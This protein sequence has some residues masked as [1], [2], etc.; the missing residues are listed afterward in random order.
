MNTSAAE[1]ADK[2]WFREDIAWPANDRPEEL[3]T[4]RLFNLIYQPFFQDK[5]QFWQEY[6][7]YKDQGLILLYV[8]FDAKTPECSYTE[9]AKFLPQIEEGLLIWE[10][11][12]TIRFAEE[13][14]AFLGIGHPD[15]RKFS[16]KNKPMPN[17]PA[18]EVCSALA[19]LKNAYNAARLAA[20]V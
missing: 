19:P 8:D 16:L 7:T 15:S 18:F 13:L 17:L 1:L 5:N 20:P 4:A 6:Q 3:R 11:K 12:K 9:T 10:K 14:T 2:L